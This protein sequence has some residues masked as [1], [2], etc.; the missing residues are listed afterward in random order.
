MNR[1]KV[2]KQLGDGTYGSV[3]KAVNRQNGEI[4]RA[5]TLCALLAYVADKAHSRHPK[6]AD[7][8]HT[9]VS[10]SSLTCAKPLN[11]LLHVLRVSASTCPAIS[12]CI[13]TKDPPCPSFLFYA[14]P[15]L[16]CPTSPLNFPNIQTIL[17]A[18]TMSNHNM[19]TMTNGTDGCEEDEEEVL[20]VGRVHAAARDQVA[21]APQPPQHRQAQGGHP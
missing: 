1:Y 21:Q 8:T 9:A 19:N 10:S 6:S 12:R 4:V 18:H 16:T 5:H 20:L 7:L 15:V 13:A 2:T 17:N 11:S 3:L 14:P